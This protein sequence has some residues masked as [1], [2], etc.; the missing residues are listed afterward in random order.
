MKSSDKCYIGVDV[1]SVSVKAAA[2]SKDRQV[3]K[4][5]YVLFEGRPLERTYKLLLDIFSEFKDR[6]NTAL[7]FTGVGGKVISKILQTQFLNEVNAHIKATSFFY[8]N[9]KTIIEIGGEDSKFIMVDIDAVTK[10]PVLKD[11]S[12][13]TICAAGTGSFLEEQAARLNMSI[14]QFSNLAMKSKNP[15]RVA[16]RCSVFAKS[17]MIHLQQEAVPEYEIVAGLCLALA[18][19]YVSTIAKGKKFIKDIVFQGG[20]ASNGGMISAFKNV[21]ELNENELIVPKHCACMGAIGSALFLLENVSVKF[22]LKS[23]EKLKEYIASQKDSSS[24]L[25]PLIMPTGYIDD[26]MSVSLDKTSRDKDARVGVYLG[27]DIGSISTNV[28]AITEDKKVLSRYYLRTLGKPIDAV[29]QGLG[30][31]GKEIGDVCIVKGVGVTG[32]GRYM[33]GDFVGA[34]VI[35]NEITA[36]AKATVEIDP[37]VDTVFEIGGQDSKYISIKN[38]LVCDFEMNKVCAAG[39]GSFLEEQADRLGINIKDEFSE[40]AFSSEQPSDLGERCTVFM[41]SALG[42]LQQ[43]SAKRSDLASGLAYSIAQNYLNKVVGKK[44][45]GDRIFFQGGVALN[46]AVVAAFESVLGKKIFVPPHND[47]TGAIGIA[48]IAREYVNSNNLESS[49]RGFGSALDNYSINTFDCSECSNKCQIRKVDFKNRASLFYGSRCEKYEIGSDKKCST[50]NILPD[51]FKQREGFLLGVFESQKSFSVGKKK[52]GIPRSLS[53]Y[54]YLPLWSRF[55]MELGFEV[56]LSDITSKDVIHKGVSMTVSEHCFPIKVLH[57]HI[58]NLVEK[59]VDYVFLP[60]VI[61]MPANSNM[62]NSYACPYVQCAPYVTKASFGVKNINVD[63]ITPTLYLNRGKKHLKDVL[64][65]VG[66]LLGSSKKEVNS[67]VDK[68]YSQQNEFYRKVKETGRQV[69]DSLNT[70]AVV[71]VGRPYN[72]CDTGLNLQIPSIFLNMGILAIPMDYVSSN[73]DGTNLRWPNMYWKYG[74]NI[75]SALNVIKKNPL[76]YPVYITNFSCGPDSFILKYAG[77]ELINKPHLTIEVDEHSAA[78]GVITRCEAFVDSFSNDVFVEGKEVDFSVAK[79]TDHPNKILYLPFMG[80]SSYA[81]AAAF[82]A[83]GVDAR[84]IPVADKQSLKLGRKHTTGKECYPCIL[85]TGDMVK[86]VKEPGFDPKNTMFFMPESNG[87]CRFGQYNRLQR[88]VLSDLG[89][90]DVPI[91]SPNQAMDF[92]KAFKK[93]G[94]NFEKR[95]WLGICAV[96]IIDKVAYELRPYEVNKGD[97]DAVYKSALD[98]ICRAIEFGDLFRQLSDIKNRFLTIRTNKVKDKPKVGIVGEIYVRSHYFANENLVH[99]IESLGAQVCLPSFSEWFYYVNFRRKEDAAL[100]RKYKQYFG[101]Y[102]KDKWQ[103]YMQVKIYKVFKPLGR[104]SEDAVEE[105]F[106]LARPYL[107]HRVEGEAPLSIGKALEFIKH[108]VSGIVNVMPFTCMPGTNASAIFMRLKQDYQVPFL[109][110]AY[111]GLE[112]DNSNTRIEAFMHQVTQHHKDNKNKNRG[113]YES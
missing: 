84:V 69:I 83:C 32:S 101:Y 29:K 106:S 103:K 59:K 73:A 98:S 93:Y 89:H 94:V 12:M 105:L 26:M 46:R 48:L 79:S 27:I 7:A 75:L 80:N 51:L 50:E 15:P 111:D 47:V 58:L 70:K 99:N 65:S 11:F 81:I 77:K 19:N 104:F 85:T 57:G 55:F 4:T 95:A 49:F 34:D 16:G 90:S 31:V 68:G 110:M 25:K 38:G 6:D 53:F 76:L 108:G 20:V 28:V 44:K 112:Q 102:V 61:S 74:Q 91:V 97:V 41:Q 63:F 64:F 18:R 42:N 71:L 33:I 37:K 17:D 66:K 39:T 2:L 60:S 24:G 30:L 78:S 88:M 67:A 62:Q 52:I 72:T 40:M 56:V 87:P 45:V 1:G 113:V 35:K 43:R 23:I 107:D 86:I 13:N 96:D 10:M 100:D 82:K 92:Y 36:Q 109:N 22:N 3:L 8:P 5:W 54:E 21:L 9:V 14:E